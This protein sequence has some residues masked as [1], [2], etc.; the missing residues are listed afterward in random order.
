[1]CVQYPAA[2]PIRLL[3]S[4]FWT[5]QEK[6]QIWSCCQHFLPATYSNE[7]FWGRA[8]RSYPEWFHFSCSTSNTLI[9]VLGDFIRV[10][11]ER[12]LDAISS[13]IKHRK[14]IRGVS[15][16]FIAHI[17]NRLMMSITLK[18]YLLFL[19][20]RNVLLVSS[21]TISKDLNIFLKASWTFCN[22]SEVY[23][24]TYLHV[25]TCGKFRH[26]LCTYNMKPKTDSLKS[27]I[28]QKSKLKT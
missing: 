4:S 23:S 22:K 21:D 13:K 15:I 17:S 18:L 28:I 2:S 27:H 20:Y 5:V 24:P 6:G 11:A 3:G 1:M 12:I 10:F 14:I 25:S 26:T 19:S 7:N 9:L 8:K 16:Q